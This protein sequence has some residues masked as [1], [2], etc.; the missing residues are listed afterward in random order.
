MTKAAIVYL[1]KGHPSEILEMSLRSLDRYFNK[2]FN[3]PVYIF[4]EECSKQELIRSWS[5]STIE[6]IQLP[7]Y[8]KLPNYEGLSVD[9][10]ERWSRGED[11]GRASFGLG[12]RQMCR[13]FLYGLFMHP[14]M[15]NLD[16]YWR[17]DDDSYLTE[18]VTYD[19]FAVMEQNGLIYGYRT[20]EAE[21]V[22]ECLG[23]DLL[24][25]EVKSFAKKEH[26]SR[27]HL[28]RLVANWKGKYKGFNYYNNFEINKVS[29]WRNHK[30][31]QHF[32]NTLDQ[33]LGFY[34]YRWGD[35]NV[36][37]MSVGLFLKPNQV[38][39]FKDIGYRHNDHY[40]IPGGD[41]VIYSKSGSPFS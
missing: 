14:K 27:R 7:D 10:V 33:T 22:R 36:R 40:A 23:L 35:A 3:Y 39:H 5:S 9:Q 2:R 1:I 37:A 17:F 21:N 16:Y 15:A 25:N 18:E 26:L 32:F 6:F 20:V 24:W 19:P 12:Y 38:H 13:F 41:K 28:N 11:G 4:H 34:K 31:Y 30:L 8:L 29:F